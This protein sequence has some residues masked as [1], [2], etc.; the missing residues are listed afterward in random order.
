MQKFRASVVISTINRSDLLIKCLKALI[1]QNNVDVNSL[2]IIVIDNG[3]TDDTRRVVESLREKYQNIKYIYEEKLGLSVARNAGARY[4]SSD[5]VCFL[6]DDA[7][8]NKNYL[9]KM[10]TS[11]ENSE[12]SCVGGRII[13]VWPN[14]SPP[15]WFSSKYN[16]VV[17]ETSFGDE[18][19]FLKKGEFPFGGNIAIR[20][21]IFEMLEGFDENLGRKGDNFISGEEVDLCYK[22]RKKRLKIFYNVE[23]KVFHIVGRKRAT[24]KY[25]IES[26]F[27][28]AITEAYQKKTHKGSIIFFVFLIV[29]IC[30]LMFVSI[31]YLFLK[32]SSLS[33]KRRFLFRCLIAWFT[34]YI[35]FLAIKN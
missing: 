29:K 24:K 23:A 17:G 19:R 16:H 6:D 33:E 10:I 3:S 28:K 9:N 31:V 15:N 25:F 26:I 7:I 22:L 30:L 21:S 4:A 35:Y 2:E 34:G 14:K 20:K 32:T 8:P 12:I 1:S 27:G 5:I 13:A 11:F 18:S